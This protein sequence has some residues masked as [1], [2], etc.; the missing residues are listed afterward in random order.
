MVNWGYVISLYKKYTMVKSDDHIDYNYFRITDKDGK[1]IGVGAVE[2]GTPN[3]ALFVEGLMDLNYDLT[4]INKQE[5]D[6]F[7]DGDVE[8]FSTFSH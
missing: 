1:S 8:T 7:N 6:D 5:Y 3:E 4:K 2:K